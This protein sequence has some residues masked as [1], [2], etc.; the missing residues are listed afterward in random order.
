MTPW[1]EETAIVAETEYDARLSGSTMRDHLSFA[2][3]PGNAVPY[4]SEKRNGIIS[5]LPA[6]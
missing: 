6:R 5:M 1:F 4:V 3:A 2:M